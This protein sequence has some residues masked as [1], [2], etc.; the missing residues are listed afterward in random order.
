MNVDRAGCRQRAIVLPFS[1]TLC[2]GVDQL[3]Y[4]LNRYSGLTL[5]VTCKSSSSFSLAEERREDETEE[6]EEEIKEE[7][8]SKCI[9]QA[10]VQ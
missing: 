7:D 9:A 1:P 6:E 5:V 8:F 4:I 2:L 3:R 10:A